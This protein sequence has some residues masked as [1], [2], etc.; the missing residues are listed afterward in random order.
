MVHSSGGQIRA[1]ET[2]AGRPNG[3]VLKGHVLPQLKDFGAVPDVRTLEDGNAVLLLP[4]DQ[5]F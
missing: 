1:R 3:S 4:L 2:A 5:R